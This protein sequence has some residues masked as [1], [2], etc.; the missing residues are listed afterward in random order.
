MNGDQLFFRHPVLQR[1]NLE[2]VTESSTMSAR[3]CPSKSKRIYFQVLD[4]F[5]KLSD[6]IKCLE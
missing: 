2:T 6:K 3:I 4:Y 1:D 5:Y